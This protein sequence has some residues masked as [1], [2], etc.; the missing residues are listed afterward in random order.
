M[1]GRLAEINHGAPLCVVNSIDEMFLADCSHIPCGSSLTMQVPELVQ[2]QLSQAIAEIGQHDFTS[3]DWPELLPHM[4]A[5]FQSGD[6][7]MIN[8]ALTTHRPPAIP[9]SRAH[10]HPQLPI[11]RQLNQHHT[12]NRPRAHSPHTH[13]RSS[14]TCCITATRAQVSSRP[15]TPCSSV[16][17]TQRKRMR[18]GARSSEFE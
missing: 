18:C 7:H 4:V 14:L 5:Q 12:H 16:I 10:R 3:G 11:A 1:Q 17:D 13:N 9:L 2:A 6:F 8:G 15:S